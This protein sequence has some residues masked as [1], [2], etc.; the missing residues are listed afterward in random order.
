MI[1]HIPLKKCLF[2]FLLLAFPGIIP[3]LGGITVVGYG[4]EHST[5]SVGQVTRSLTVNSSSRRLTTPT[6]MD[7]QGQMYWKSR[8]RDES[9]R[10]AVHLTPLV[11]L[12]IG[13][14]IFF[15]GQDLLEG[16]ENREVPLNEKAIRA[17]SPDRLVESPRSFVDLLVGE[18]KDELLQSSSI[19]TVHD[20]DFTR[21]MIDSRLVREAGLRKLSGHHITIYT[22]L[23]ESVDLKDLPVVLDLAVDQW[24]NYFHIQ[25]DQLSDWAL[26]GYL[27]NDETRF[28]PSGLLPASLPK[29]T[30]GY[31]R[32]YEFWMREQPSAYYRRHLMLH[33]AAHAFMQT[34][35]GG[36]GP[37]W[38]AEGMAE[39]LA[40]HRWK[41]RRL[42]TRYM[43]ASR[44]ETPYWG[45]IK[46]VQDE[47]AAGRAMLLREVMRMTG[48]AHDDVARYA[49]AW[50]AA[51]FLDGNPMFRSRFRALRTVAAGP[52]SQVTHL[53]EESMLAQ[54][55]ELDEQW[56]IFVAEIDYGYDLT[57]TAIE[58]GGGQ[59]FPEAGAKVSFLANRGWQSTGVLLKSGQTYR[60]SC[61]GRFVIARD[62]R[63]KQDWWCEPGGV[64]IRYHRGLPLGMVIGTVRPEQ[65]S[66]D[67][68]SLGH[69]FTVGRGRT[70]VAPV[71]G[72][73][74]VRV[75]DSP[76]ELADNEGKISLEVSHVPLVDD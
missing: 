40:T 66:P 46:V 19:N 24:A 32:G 58:Y 52:P 36:L 9:W 64:T 38:Y 14:T 54:S 28:V 37:P 74:Y 55:R 69:P 25:T 12:V 5:I 27:I 23:P 62:A 56:R 60:L 10:L 48:P 39:L 13:L 57:R 18:Y 3:E 29:F 15:P 22:D 51:A 65:I 47:F 4:I 21:P 26:N 70:F 73:M 7:D 34:L 11:L 35:L 44:D 50:A 31:Q 1:F 6:Q 16:H 68:Q 72:T 2:S 20:E 76:S 63:D 45:R 49:W 43:P 75:N 59:M 67:Q 17:G 42:L 61:S 8:Y 71:D 33:E 53:F 30:N 41:E